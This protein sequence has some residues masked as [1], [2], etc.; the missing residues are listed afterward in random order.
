[1]PSKRAKS[2]KPTR[3]AGERPKSSPD[4]AK[5]AAS[6]TPPRSPAPGGPRAGRAERPRKPKPGRA[7]KLCGALTTRGTP[8]RNP[9]GQGTDH[10][11]EGPCLRHDRPQAL[12]AGVAPPPSTSSQYAPNLR[13]KLQENFEK[14]HQ[15]GLVGDLTEELYLLRACVMLLTEEG[16]EYDASF[17]RDQLTPLL[18]TIGDLEARY[19]RIQL[20]R[21]GLIEIERMEYLFTRLGD[22]VRRFV[23]DAKQNACADEIREMIRELREGR[24]VGR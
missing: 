13:G 10:V 12:P 15:A 14:L 23:P 8:C 24:P 22:L 1:M 11:G 3:L 9:A 19:S 5:A 21:K 20:E 2:R 17:F 4:E 6:S 7:A 16:G 18:K